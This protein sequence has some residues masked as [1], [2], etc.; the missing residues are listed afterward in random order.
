MGLI[1]SRET[2][3]QN[4]ASPTHIDNNTD[5]GASVLTSTAIT[6]VKPTTTIKRTTSPSKS[7]L[8]NGRTPQ[9][10]QNHHVRTASIRSRAAIPMPDPSELDKLFAKVLVRDFNHTQKL[11]IKLNY[12]PWNKSKLKLWSRCRLFCFLINCDENVL[13]DDI[14]RCVYV[15]ESAN[16][17]IYLFFFISPLC[18]FSKM[19]TVP[20]IYWL[21]LVEHWMLMEKNSKI[22][23]ITC[24]FSAHASQFVEI[25]V[26]QIL[27][28]K[29]KVQRNCCCCCFCSS[30]LFHSDDWISQ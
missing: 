9:Q 21:R 1:S 14:E 8:N 24:Q 12:S 26:S 6:N 17:C 11:S 16:Q 27:D 13:T 23:L 19:I 22:I 10:Q 25:F 18:L 5:D 20:I 30:H 3:A 29:L 4:Q 2:S 7:L 15:E 28:K